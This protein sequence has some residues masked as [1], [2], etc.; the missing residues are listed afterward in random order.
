MNAEGMRVKIVQNFFRK[1]V[2]FLAQTLAQ[3][4]Y[5]VLGSTYVRTVVRWLQD[6]WRRVLEECCCE[7]YVIES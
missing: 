7:S 6:V 4:F 5:E 3:L 1:H 2:D